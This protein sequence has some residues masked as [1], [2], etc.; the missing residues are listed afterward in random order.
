MIINTQINQVNSD[1]I[2]HGYWESYY[3]NG[4]LMYKGNWNNGNRHGYWEDYHFNGQ[5]AYKGYFIK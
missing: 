3:F 1:G 5:L 4:Q 2:K